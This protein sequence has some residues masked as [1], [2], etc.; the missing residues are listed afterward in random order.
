MLNWRFALDLAELSTHKDAEMNFGQAYW[1]DFFI[2]Y[3]SKLIKNKYDENLVYQNGIYS[4]KNNGVSTLIIHP[5]W[6]DQYISSLLDGKY[7]GSI[8]MMDI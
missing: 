1:A 6:S 7:E 5:F 2:N 8:H 3:L 4:F